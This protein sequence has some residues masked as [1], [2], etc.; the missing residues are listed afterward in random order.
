[1]N[2]AHDLGGMH[3]FGPVDRSQKQNFA[4]QWEQKVFALTLACGFQGKWNLDKSRFAREQMDPAHYLGSSYYEHWLHGLEHLLVNE[5]LLSV[6]ELATGKAQQSNTF[7]PIAKNQ[8]AGILQSGAP[9]A[10]PEGATQKYQVGESI[11]TH[12]SHPKSHTRLPRY[13]RGRVGKI[14]SH[15]G[16]HIFPDTH[17]ATGE[18]KPEHL[19]TVKFIGQDL[20]GESAAEPNTAVYV[21]VFEPYIAGNA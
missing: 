11:V 3:G 18:K 8:V 12:N 13:I 4:A 14:V 19:Y 5:G 1:M 2:G 17:A 9:T 20:W 21:D 10:L 15:H 7:I 6:D 16:A